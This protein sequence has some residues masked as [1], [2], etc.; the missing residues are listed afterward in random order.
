MNK[1][2]LL[3][4]MLALPLAG[5][6][7]SAQAGSNAVA[8]VDA[9]ASTLGTGLAVAF[10]VGDSVAARV[11][12]NQFNLSFNTTT[13]SAT[14][15]INYSGNLKLS[16]VE[17]LADWHPFDGLFHLTGGMMVNNNK[18]EATGIDQATG[19]TASATVTFSKTAPYLGFGWSGQAKNTGWSFK[20]DIGVLFQGAP[21]AT[22]TSAN[23]TLAANLA[24]E[25]AALN[26]KL[27][28]FKYYPVIS[29]AVGYAF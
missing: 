14:S 15:T 11:G 8:D 23:P 12:F 3:S 1:S 24:T 29:F 26:D 13:T 5:W 6:A 4:A 16:T 20:S 19:A 28:N 2:V 17:L 9:H 27:K 18:Y 7:A 25:Q 22:L 21:N 10:P